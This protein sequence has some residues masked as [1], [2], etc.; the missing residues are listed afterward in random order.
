MKEND[1][2][3]CK[4]GKC[5]CHLIKTKDNPTKPQG[6]TK[7]INIGETGICEYLKS[8]HSKSEKT[9][10]NKKRCENKQTQT[11]FDGVLMQNRE[12][13][14]CR[15]SM[16]SNKSERFSLS[17]VE[18]FA[19]SCDSVSE[20]NQICDFLRSQPV[21]EWIQH[22]K[23]TEPT[24]ENVTNSVGCN[25]Q[26]SSINNGQTTHGKH[27][28]CTSHSTKTNNCDRG[29]TDKKTDSFK[30]GSGRNFQNDLSVPPKELSPCTKKCKVSIV[31]EPRPKH[32]GPCKPKNS[33]VQ[34]TKI[35]NSDQKCQD[36][37]K[38]KIH[39]YTNSTNNS[40][41]SVNDCLDKTLE[42]SNNKRC[43][44]CCHL[45]KTKNPC[46]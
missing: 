7:V 26:L 34:S 22:Q 3:V 18:I 17:T 31:E 9:E 25:N 41:L 16:S 21:P 30:C 43:A 45:T 42:K 6:D 13:E 40:V 29:M 19:K 5:C 11:D 35:N 15:S 46:T 4:F 1:G 38:L 44:C 37:V 23:F 20:S 10:P 33:D 39:E 8:I 24:Q 32:L 27:K 28:C 36:S 12:R 2:N 14:D